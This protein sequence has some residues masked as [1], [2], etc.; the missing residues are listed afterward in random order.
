MIK[1]ILQQTPTPKRLV[2]SL[3]SAPD[4]P[5][6][7]VRQC[8]RW[9]ELFGL[10]AAAV[11]VAVGRLVRA[12][13]LRSVRR[14]VYAIGP[15]GE[16]LVATARGW[17]R[18][19]ERLARWEGDWILVYTAQLGRSD[20]SALRGRERAMRLEGMQPLRPDLWCR[21]AN[22]REPLAQTRQRLCT[23][24]LEETATVLRAAV[25][26]PDSP[27][28]IAALWPTQ[29]LERDYRRFTSAL[30]SSATRLRRA[31]LAAA[32]RES[33]LLGQAVIRRINSD[34]LLPDEFIDTAA[35]RK[36]IETMQAYD[37]QGRD[38]WS[39]FRSSD[40]GQ[41]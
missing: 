5:E 28:D 17:R 9:G 35:R 22:Y 36:L 25:V 30:K 20:R 4:M 31:P 41:G 6:I 34:P 23:L 3:L 16:S 10:D 14:G 13:L 26:L 11:R 7:T 12:G 15:R 29:A 40:G 27:S 1:T 2:L 21:P 19:E 38:I 18:A 24:G 37:D 8:T 32:A 33:F 39:H